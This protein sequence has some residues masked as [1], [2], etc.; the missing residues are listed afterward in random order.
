MAE[1]YS[2]IVPG[3]PQ[4][5]G[6]S[7]RLSLALAESPLGTHAFNFM[8]K[9]RVPRFMSLLRNSK[10]PEEPRAELPQ[11]PIGDEI[12]I[13][14]L[15]PHDRLE[16]ALHSLDHAGTTR[17]A[18]ASNARPTVLD[19]HFAYE[20]GLVTPNDVAERLI[21]FL[22][23]HN[24]KHCWLSQWSAEDIRRQAAESTARYA[25]GRSLSVFDGVPFCVKDM[26]DAMPYETSYG[27]KFM[28]KF[29][30]AVSD[31]PAVATLK[32]LGAIL[33]GKAAMNEFGVLPHG[34][35]AHQGQWHCTS[36]SL[37][38]L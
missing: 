5:S 1:T 26:L 10:Y 16:A 12:I 24:A 30:P 2:P 20:N 18:T 11:H 33:I 8:L 38:A 21:S 3:T 23:R 32:Q 9:S 13:N 31:A 25:A 28:G 37:T 34:F 29:R 15:D 6:F 14:S 7:L 22:E 35:N 36:Q 17:V 19:Y 4:L 27:T